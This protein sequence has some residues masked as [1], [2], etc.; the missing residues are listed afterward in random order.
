VIRRRVLVVDDDARV[1]AAVRTL[2]AST[3]DLAVSGGLSTTEA[4]D[5][6]LAGPLALRAALG[7]M[8]LVDVPH[9]E[10]HRSLELVSRLAVSGPVVTF[11]IDGSVRRP[12]LRAGAQAF[13]TKDGHPDTVMRALRAA[14]R[15]GYVV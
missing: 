10:A 1:R 8:A 7:D 13:L 4:L 12:A 5:G 11:S 2:L 15:V 14:H 6:L 9:A 3:S